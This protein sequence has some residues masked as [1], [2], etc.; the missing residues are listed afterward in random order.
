[1]PPL[2]LSPSSLLKNPAARLLSTAL[3]AFIHQLRV[4][5]A[6]PRD[7]FNFQI[8]YFQAATAMTTVR[9][10]RIKAKSRPF[11]PRRRKK[12]KVHRIREPAILLTFKTGFPTAPLQLSRFETNNHPFKL[13]N[14]IRPQ[15]HTGRMAAVCERTAAA[16]AGCALKFLLVRCG[17]GAVTTLEDIG[18]R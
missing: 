11:L 10:L 16:Q 14:S 12:S 3:R 15:R 17:D 2:S 8:L 5:S 6:I 4:P 7:S 9:S 13:I 1:M 18:G